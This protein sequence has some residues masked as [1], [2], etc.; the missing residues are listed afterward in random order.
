MTNQL[1]HIAETIEEKNAGLQSIAEPWTDKG[2]DNIRV[3]MH[4]KGQAP[5]PS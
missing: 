4:G 3:E 1:L 2:T 5:N